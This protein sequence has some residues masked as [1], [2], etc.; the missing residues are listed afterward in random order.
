MR[1]VVSEDFLPLLQRL[2]IQD[3]K[4]YAQSGTYFTHLFPG[5]YESILEHFHFISSQTD[6]FLSQIQ[7]FFQYQNSQV[8][9]IC[10]IQTQQ[11]Q[12]IWSKTKVLLCQLHSQEK[13]RKLSLM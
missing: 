10:L 6:C 3:I 1:Q 4:E 7:L 8:S 9:I 13:D 2:I 12:K 5:Q 11:K